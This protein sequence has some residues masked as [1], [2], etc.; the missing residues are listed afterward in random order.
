MADQN[1]E[2]QTCQSHVDDDLERFRRVRHAFPLIQ[3]Y[4][5]DDECLALNS[6]DFSNIVRNIL[7]S[8][9]RILIMRTLE[10]T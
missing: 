5:C 6:A 3:V 1:P 9:Q 4:R 10:V 2:D 8:D 7:L